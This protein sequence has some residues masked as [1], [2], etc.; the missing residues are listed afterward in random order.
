MVHLLTTSTSPSH[1]VDKICLLSP[2]QRWT[3]ETRT[4]PG[5]KASF[6]ETSSPQPVR[7][8][9]DHVHCQ[10]TMTKWNWVFILY[11]WRKLLADWKNYPFEQ[12]WCFAIETA[13]IFCK[14]Q[15]CVPLRPCLVSIEK[16]S[17][18]FHDLCFILALKTPQSCGCQSATPTWTAAKNRIWTLM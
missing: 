11:F 10:C 14:N 3:F 17:D 5:P 4:P 15:T 9:V 1:L 6:L 16:R 2:S 13:N 8:E 7:S 18:F 12:T